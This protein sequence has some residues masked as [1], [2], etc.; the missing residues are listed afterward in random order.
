MRW[1]NAK[2][3][4]NDQ[5]IRNRKISINHIDLSVPY[6]NNSQLQKKKLNWNK[7]CCFLEINQIFDKIISMSLKNVKTIH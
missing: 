3:I 2:T 4:F 6:W 1:I 7:H 5:K